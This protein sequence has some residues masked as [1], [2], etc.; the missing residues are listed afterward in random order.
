V[1]SLD[2][3][4]LDDQAIIAA[5]QWRF[6]PGR[7]SGKP[8]AVLVTVMLDFWIRGSYASPRWHRARDPPRWARLLS[9]CGI[10]RYR[11][12]FSAAAT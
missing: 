3:G 2:P 6:E 5:S 4:G 10:F 9:D 12:A 1:R 11:V 7:L 8:V